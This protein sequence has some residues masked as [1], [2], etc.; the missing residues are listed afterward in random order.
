[1]RTQGE[2]SYELDEAAASPRRFDSS[3]AVR[4]AES[5][6]E[7]VDQLLDRNLAEL[8]QELRVAFSRDAR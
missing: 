8:L 4:A 7:T 1:M 3:A 6:G 2:Q 5:R